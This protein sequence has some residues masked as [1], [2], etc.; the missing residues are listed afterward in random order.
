MRANVERLLVDGAVMAVTQP[1]VSLSDGSVLGYELLARMPGTGRGPEHWLRRAST[2]GLR[3][4]LELACLRALS[5]LGPPPAGR[6]LF[7]N[8]SAATLRL[9]EARAL[10]AAVPAP[11]VLEVPAGSDEA[12]GASALRAALEPY[13][14][15][16]ARL[17]VDDGGSVYAS[18][19]LVVELRPGFLKLS[20]RA[21]RGL[22]DDPGRQALVRA[23]AAFG[24]EVGAA[25]V[26]E[27]VETL[28]EHEALRAAD[29][30]YAQGYLYARPAPGWPTPRSPGAVPRPRRGGQVLPSLAGAGDASAACAAVV[31]H[32]FRR[33]GLLPSIYLMRG[34]RLRCEAARGYWQIFDGMPVD[35]GVIGRTYATGE[36][37]LLR[38]AT[39]SEDY[40]EA[41]P[42]VVDEL[43]VP[44]RVG[45]RLVGVL[46]VEATER[47]SGAVEREVDACVA[48]L[49]ERLE[50]LGLP[51]E[52][53]AQK[54]G[55]HAAGLAELA[56]RGTEPDLHEA[57]LAAAVEVSG[58]DSAA[59]CL[60]QDG[61][62]VVRAA[63]GPLAPALRGL[64]P[65][66]L[67]S[68]A[69]WTSAGT[70][71]YTT[72]TAS[73]VGFVGHEELR[74]QGLSSLVLLGLASPHGTLG[75]LVVAARATVGV[76]TE[77]VS[78]LELLAA[79]VSACLRVGVGVR[80]LRD[81]AD[82]DALTG[83]GHHGAFHAHLPRAR[84]HAE[85]ARLAVLYVDLDRFKAVNDTHGHAEGDRLLVAV[86]GAMQRVLRGRD[87]VFRIG[88]DEFAVLAEV[89]GDDEALA[90]GTRL[91][92][93][94]LDDTGT[95]LSLGVAVAGPGDS[96]TSLLA[97]ADEALYLVK[98]DGRGDVRLARTPA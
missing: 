90:L 83:L 94:V 46:N 28:A 62:L 47:L 40:L 5:T 16:G 25:V 63:H 73:G 8:A 84:A 52:R 71:S 53:P 6:A 88:G 1:V 21:V 7:L 22:Q 2:F 48:L 56:G 96:D 18:L 44:L 79:E 10:L 67:E 95:S 42:G 54:L 38:G 60:V 17:A 14:A 58:M 4:D 76:D 61:R 11:L 36:R 87:L 35:A 55:R 66:Q 13:V 32:L 74:T 97:R 57:A 9:P 81:K 68:M 23:L 34:G 50:E 92:Q 89:G 39:A 12:E 91:R 27:G 26:A 3:D 78:L 19:E 24:R 75:V 37:T 29:V 85:G 43:C 59:L 64:A 82:R 70:S 45:G 65:A 41:A 77:H 98:R 51:E 30:A 93:A 69:H 80:A 15:D 31:H 49:G 86:A 33:G 72:G 20:P